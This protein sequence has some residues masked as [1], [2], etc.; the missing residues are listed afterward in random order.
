LVGAE[1]LW[2]ALFLQRGEREQP[3]ARRGCAR[4]LQRHVYTHGAAARRRRRR[5]RR[6]DGRGPCALAARGAVQRAGTRQ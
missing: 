6:G 5:A 1:R 4:G 2:R 3:R